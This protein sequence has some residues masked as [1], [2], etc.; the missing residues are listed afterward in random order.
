MQSV[1][2]DIP[3]EPCTDIIEQP[4]HTESLSDITTVPLT[5]TTEDISTSA[6][7]NT[8][9]TI[10]QNASKG[11]CF[12]TIYAWLCNNLLFFT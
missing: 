8:T 6:S 1:T 11:N 4:L 2:T 5:E 10:L 9:T 12:C 3:E 7:L